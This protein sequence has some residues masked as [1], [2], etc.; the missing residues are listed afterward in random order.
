M[1]PHSEV[2]LVD[3]LTTWITKSVTLVPDS[4]AHPV[5]FSSFQGLP[6]WPIQSGAKY[7][8]LVVRAQERC[9]A[10]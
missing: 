1:T 9:V 2:L 10:S 6:N 5:V 8:S 4:H 3:V 7:V